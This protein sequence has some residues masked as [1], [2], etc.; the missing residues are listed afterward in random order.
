[1]EVAQAEGAQESR[2]LVLTPV[3]KNTSFAVDPADTISYFDV[4]LSSANRKLIIGRNISGDDLVSYLDNLQAQIKSR[5]NFEV[6][7]AEVEH[8]DTL[9][10]L[11]ERLSGISS[12][13]LD[14]VDF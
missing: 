9:F 1:M 10:D 11:V 2:R 6:K 12:E 3:Y 8:H 13:H 7:T 14:G 5:G 4:R